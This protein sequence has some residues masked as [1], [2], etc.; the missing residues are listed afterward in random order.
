[1]T[2]DKKVLA[3]DQ[4]SNTACMPSRTAEYA[5]WTDSKWTARTLGG[6]GERCKTKNKMMH[7]T[8]TLV[9]SGMIV[10][11]LRKDSDQNEQE[12]YET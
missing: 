7:W 8:L 4:I 9:C 12:H 2:S 1:M 11:H 10:E 5:R 6:E 3:P